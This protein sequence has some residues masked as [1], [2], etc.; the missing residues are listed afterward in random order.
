MSG[1]IILSD[2]GTL[3]VNDKNLVT[4]QE[5]DELNEKLN[6][7]NNMAKDPSGNLMIFVKPIEISSIISQSGLTNNF[8]FCCYTITIYYT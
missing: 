1:E 2:L 7:L 5:I 8:I 4:K 6:N 3:V